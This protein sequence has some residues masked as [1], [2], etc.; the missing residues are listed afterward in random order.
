VLV[1]AALAALLAWGL[2]SHSRRHAANEAA[3]QREAELFARRLRGPTATPDRYAAGE[4][5]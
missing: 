1:G 4:S 5:A 2:L 3:R